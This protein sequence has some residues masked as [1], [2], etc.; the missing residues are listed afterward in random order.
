MMK[1]LKQMSCCAQN[2][3]SA[4][5]SEELKIKSRKQR[6]HACL[7]RVGQKLRLSVMKTALFCMFGPGFS[8]SQLDATCW[9]TLTMLWRL[10]SLNLKRRHCVMS[11]T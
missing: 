5:S 9:F 4:F 8:L 3:R 10:F 6:L 11:Q 1:S 2:I 7:Q